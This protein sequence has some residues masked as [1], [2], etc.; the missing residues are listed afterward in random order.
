MIHMANVTKPNAHNADVKSAGI[1]RGTDAFS[2]QKYSGLSEYEVNLVLAS[3][4]STAV[5][6]SVFTK[7]AEE[8]DKAKIIRNSASFPEF[9]GALAQIGPVLGGWRKYEPEELISRVCLAALGWARVS[10]IT[11]AYGIRD[12][13][14]ELIEKRKVEKRVLEAGTFGE[15]YKTLSGIYGENGTVIDAIESFRNGESYHSNG[16]PNL[17]KIPD[18]H[19]IR[20]SVIN[21]L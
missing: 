11:H 9:F 6:S 3:Y 18:E 17:S 7:P 13:T 15:L 10:D 20:R 4:L 1:L 5:S 21:L 16:T 2:M 14:L 19:G 8:S 12:K